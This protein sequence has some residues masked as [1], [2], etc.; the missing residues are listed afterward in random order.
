[1]IVV[2]GDLFHDFISVSNESTQL[3]SSFLLGLMTI[4]PVILTRG[5]HDYDK[6][7]MNR[8]DSVQTV[9]DLRASDGVRYLNRTGFY[10]DQNVVWVVWHHGEEIS[11]WNVAR[12]ASKA[13]KK[14]E[15]PKNFY[16]DDLE[17][18]FDQYGD[19]EGCLG[20]YTFI[21][22]FHDPLVGS[23]APNGEVFREGAYL[24]QSD[25]QGHWALLGDIHL[26]QFFT[27][28]GATAPFGGY[29]GS[30]V[31][32][33]FGEPDQGHGYFLLDIEAGTIKAVEVPS[34]TKFY[35][36]RVEPGVNYDNLQLKLPENLV[37]NAHM[38][39]YWTDNAVQ[40]TQT[41][42]A[43][44]RKYLREAGA[45]SVTFAPHAVDQQ[46]A[47]RAGIGEL[48]ELDIA[49]VQ[50]QHRLLGDHLRTASVPED[51]IT[52]VLELDKQVDERLRIAQAAEGEVT[53]PL[54]AGNAG[55]VRLLN[56][57]IDNFQSIEKLTL[58]F[59]Q[60]P[61]L[62][63][64][65]GPNETGKT[66]AFMAMMY[67]H[68]GNTLGTVVLKN[69]EVKGRAE[70]NGDNRFINNKRDQDYCDVSADYD[71]GGTLLRV[72]RR[73]E[74]KWKRTKAG[75]ATEISK[76]SSDYKVELLTADRLVDQD[77]S[78]DK[79]KRTEKL[80]LEVFGSFDDFLRGVFFSADTMG[81]LLSLDRSVFID[82]ILRDLKLDVYERK[83]AIFRAWK[84]EVGKRATRLVLDENA[85]QTKLTEIELL[86][87]GATERVLAA[88]Q[89]QQEAL[90]ALT[91]EQTNRE[92]LLTKYQALPVEL[93]QTDE[94]GIRA[95]VQQAIDALHRHGTKEADL[96]KC[97]AELPDAYD[98]ARFTYLKTEIDASAG[99]VKSQQLGI[100]DLQNQADAE[101]NRI[102]H[103][104]GMRTQLKQQAEYVKREHAQQRTRLETELTRQDREITALEKSTVCPTCQ[105]VK[106]PAAVAAIAQ[107]VTQ[108]Q[109][110]RATYATETTAQIQASEDGQLAQLRG[111]Y[112]ANEAQLAP[113]QTQRA[114]LEAQ[115][116]ALTA[117]IDQQQL[118]YAALGEELVALTQV[119]TKVE[120]RRELEQSGVNFPVQRQQLEFTLAEARRRLGVYE[121][122]E[123]IRKHNESIKQQVQ[124]A[125]ERIA[126][127]KAGYDGLTSE[128]NQLSLVQVPQ[129]QRQQQSVADQL[130][131]YRVQ[132]AREHVWSLYEKSISRE[133]LPMQLVRRAL[134]TINEQMAELLDGLCFSI[135]LDE[136]LEFRMLDHRRPGVEQHILQGSGMERTFASLVLRLGLR[137]LNHRARW[138]ILILDEMLGKLDSEATARYA[139]LLRTA[140][141]SIEHVVV[142]EHHGEGVLQPDRVL[143]VHAENGVSRY[144][145]SLN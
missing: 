83:L 143:Q 25:L 101:L 118:A 108:R 93:Q 134:G 107:E 109:Q 64:I 45:I 48:D 21:D 18:L 12:E 43:K 29:P 126:D 87:T 80:A 46:G 127:K 30:L 40:H 11:P 102:V 31:Q 115:M 142:I 138:N 3:A 61:G 66:T 59:E 88:T 9:A 76:C 117:G 55:Y 42:K 119:K 1:V 84:S 37:P 28:P 19:L 122:A 52:Q 106:T 27:R 65:K 97:C 4:A 79:R 91:R 78:V 86:L 54:V 105:Q 60:N 44:L 82:T 113:H 50:V 63:Q 17:H 103:L 125:A 26:R 39:A 114:N 68:F 132:Q 98:E 41:N 35:T 69:G 111:D 104:E 81:G 139:D 92:Q 71:A 77:Q 124:R 36:I 23:T 24:K 100:R 110:Q 62:W 128:L 53:G 74:R 144:Q 56:L 67:L 49:D 90:K 123:A 10:V 135:Y 8:T 13:G 133:G 129:L 85:E 16:A 70:K 137:R 136:D 33:H 57:T 72:T 89:E 94:A 6:F 99:W 145:L 121:Q 20:Y 96:H 15:Y 58:N 51:V 73:T 141:G 116:V 14:Y 112:R 95:A 47:M 34:D 130:S 2:A 32:Q 5:N 38:R 140:C 131:A 75:E 120:R 7:R 22:I